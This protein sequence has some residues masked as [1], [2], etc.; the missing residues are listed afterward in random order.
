M[1]CK[2]VVAH[3]KIPLFH[4]YSNTI[5]PYHFTHVCQDF[6][7]NLSAIAVAAAYRPALEVL[8][9]GP[10]VGLVPGMCLIE[11]VVV[12]MQL[13]EPSW[14]IGLGVGLDSRKDLSVPESSALVPCPTVPER[15]KVLLNLL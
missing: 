2:E 11:G 14:L 4:R 1:L 9:A 10:N 12:S 6:I 15:I 7:L 5:L 13:V 3:K 8:R